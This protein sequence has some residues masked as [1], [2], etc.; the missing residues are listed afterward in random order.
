[1]T[2]CLSYQ[3]LQ[4]LVY[5]YLW[6]NMYIKRSVGM[7]VC[8]CVPYRNL[9]FWTN[10]SQILHRGS[11]NIGQN[12]FQ[13][14]HTQ[15]YP[16]IL[17]KNAGLKV[18]QRRTTFYTFPNWLF[19]SFVIKKRTMLIHWI[20]PRTPRQPCRTSAQL[21][22][23]GPSSRSRPWR[24]LSTSDTSNTGTYKPIELKFFCQ[25]LWGI[26]CWQWACSTYVYMN[27]ACAIMYN[28]GIVVGYCVLTN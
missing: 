4:I 13:Q 3:S 27:A 19:S 10:L 1:L 25:R 22:S 23:T 15:M 21:L 24:S 8:M 14:L 6:S 9:H 20:D 18:A 2:W 26:F 28:T 16:T 17:D 11:Q 12:I 7:G 5:K